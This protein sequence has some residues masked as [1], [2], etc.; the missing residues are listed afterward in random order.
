MRLGV[1][2]FAPQP[3]SK[4]LLTHDYRNFRKQ[5]KTRSKH[6]RRIKYKNKSKRYRRL[7]WKNR[8]WLLIRNSNPRVENLEAKLES[9]NDE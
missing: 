9:G 5:I 7:Q 4:R 3:H 6:A 1:G 2:A 8:T